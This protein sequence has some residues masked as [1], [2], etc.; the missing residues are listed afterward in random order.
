MNE[1]AVPKG[2]A[3]RSCLAAAFMV[4][5]LYTAG[6]AQAQAPATA[7][8]PL[9]LQQAMQMALDGHPLLAIRRGGI[10]AAGQDVEAAKWKRY[11]TATLDQSAFVGQQNL[12]TTNQSQYTATWRVQ[13][14]LWTGGKITSEISMADSRKG[15]AEWSLVETEQELLTRVAQSFSD[16]VR[17]QERNRIASD[18]LVEHQRL[19]DQIRRRTDQQVS[20]EVDVLLAQARLQQAQAESLTLRSNLST[21][22]ATLEQ[23]VGVPV[24]AVRMPERVMTPTM[25]SL[26]E[27]LT[28]GVK[29]S[30]SLMRLEQ[31]RQAALS[32]VEG[33]RAS[34]Y[35]NVSLRYEK[36]MGAASAVPFD[37][38]SVALE[39]QPGSGLSAVSGLGASAKRLE[40]AASAIEAGQREVTER[41]MNQFNEAQTFAQQVG[42]A[43]DYARTASDV[44]ASYLRQYTAGRKSWLDVMNA[45]REQ[46]QSRYSAADVTSGTLLS[47]LKLEILAGLLTRDTISKIQ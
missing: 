1:H 12:T 7:S 13:Q 15:V 45:Q 11:P 44:M 20:S 33:K 21:V 3:A 8:A 2:R 14:P 6:A 37:R 26:A 30:P 24:S 5:S 47:V 43:T 28:Q 31:E 40:M 36:F 22:K 16:F 10:Q 35:P 32:D 34:L 9:G 25:A 18:N 19:Y 27:Y 46:T 4:M 42:P 17:L 41:I 38:W 39:Y 29:A 23:L